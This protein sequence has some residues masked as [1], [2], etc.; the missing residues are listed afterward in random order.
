MPNEV[1]I[2]V[3]VYNS[4]KAGLD[5]VDKDVDDYAKRF[6]ET[7][8]KRFSEALTTNLTQNVTQK[9]RTVGEQAQQSARDAGD[10][11]GTTMS[12][13]IT[14]KI[15]DRLRTVRDRVSGNDSRSTSTSRSDSGGNGDRDRVHVDVDVDKQS[16][17]QKLG[18]LGKAAGD[19][20][21]G[22]FGDGLKGG[23][24]SVFSGDWITTVLKGLVV[25]FATFT[26]APAIG[27]AVTSG[28]LL[29]LGGGVIGAGVFAAIK[30][31][32]ALRASFK[33]L[34]DVFKGEAVK[35]G[36]NFIEPVQN[37]ADGLGNVFNQ[38][39]PM[40]EEIGRAFGPLSDNLGRGLIAMLQN[41]L[42]GILR[43]TEA[44]G[45][46]I[47]VLADNLP[48]LGDEMGKFFDHIKNGAPDAAV[49]FNDLLHAV[50]LVIRILAN[51]I[52]GLTQ[53]YSVARKVMV[54]LVSLFINWASAAVGAAA[55]A[56]G[57]M[58]GIGPKLNAA[59]HQMANFKERWNGYLRQ[60]PSEKTF[61]VR[62]RV[63]GQSA[64]SAAIRT[65]RLLNG[66]DHGGIKGAADGG[67]KNGLTWV[68]ESGPEL[69]KLPPGAQVSTA[70]DSARMA[71]AGG[72]SQRL[73][74]RL[75][76]DRSTE[77]GVVDALLKMLRTEIGNSYGGNV[78]TALGR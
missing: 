2:L 26:L 22:A 12:E 66:M 77:R 28:V 54:G 24:T 43:A 69:V 23:L 56:F 63:L 61:T 53:M 46:L 67:L 60:M 49:F 40:I 62:F 25:S 34:G 6:S 47:Q 74:V 59:A 10:R 45:P 58:P 50:R 5:A 20:I 1:K 9:L 68:G 29:A 70:G 72:G 31:D 44:A 27:A 30:S 21:S 65:A 7:F 35:F 14:T 76:V 19:K 16:F 57:W 38:I 36:Q 33:F 15:T 73:D 41:A 55:I 32:P 3:R 8:T 75:M 42:P 51:L 37:F 13:R 18:G 39:R 11:I 4:G 48:G 64:A 71:G 17:L 78:Q 52:D